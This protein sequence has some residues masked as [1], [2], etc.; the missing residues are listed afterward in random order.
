MT[1]ALKKAIMH[2]SKL[3]T[4]FHNMRREKIGTNARNKGTF[5]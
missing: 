1:K 5:A 3:K 2:K 4:I